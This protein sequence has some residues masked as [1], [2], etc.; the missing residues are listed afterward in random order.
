MVF[1]VVLQSGFRVVF[2][3]VLR[4]VFRVVFMASAAHASRCSAC[5][6]SEVIRAIR[7]VRV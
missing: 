3:V 1:R 7:V 4:V 5:R 6:W 2:R